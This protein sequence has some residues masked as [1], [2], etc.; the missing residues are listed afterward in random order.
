M[1]K[2]DYV[3]FASQNIEFIEF[4]VMDPFSED[5]SS[6]SDKDAFNGTNDGGDV[7]VQIGNISED[8]LRDGR[9]AFE[10]GLPTPNDPNVDV[11]TTIWG[12]VSNRINL[13]NAFDNDASAREQQDVGFDGMGDRD[14]FKLFSSYIDYFDG[15]LPDDIG[16]DPAADNYEYF[17]ST[18]LDAR[19]ANIIERYKNFNGTDGNSP[20]QESTGLDYVSTA[21][22]LPDIEDLNRDNTL[23]EGE[24]YYEYKNAL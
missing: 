23:S 22:T 19:E 4:W 9:K 6:I 1:R 16:V 11:D 12:F 3:D 24:S 5:P 15:T 13:V 10:N 17:R 8:I 2:I 7:Y 21:T 18:D 14:E 20:T